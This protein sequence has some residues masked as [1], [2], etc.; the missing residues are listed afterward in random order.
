MIPVQVSREFVED[1]LARTNLSPEEK[2]QIRDLS[3]PA[4]HDEV[5]RLFASMGV[6]PDRLQNRMGGSP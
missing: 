4:D 5:L 2:Q 1:I 6:T 3:Y